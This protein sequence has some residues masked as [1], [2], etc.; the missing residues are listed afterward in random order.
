LLAPLELKKP[1]LFKFYQNS[2]HWNSSINDGHKGD[3]SGTPK[4]EKNHITSMPKSTYHIAKFPVELL[5][6]SEQNGVRLRA[7][8]SSLDRYC[9]RILDLNDIAGVMSAIFKYCR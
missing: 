2:Y 3:F 7:T 6:L 9:F 8:V 4:K 1:K 5:T